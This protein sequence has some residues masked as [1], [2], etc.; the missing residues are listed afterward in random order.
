TPRRVYTHI[1]PDGDG[2]RDVFSV[3]YTLDEPARAILIVNQ[4][5][6]EVTHSK[7]LH[8][9]LAWNGK[10]DGRPVRPGN[11]TLEV[12]A[13]DPAGNVAKPFPFAIVTVRYVELGRTRILAR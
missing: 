12:S 1:S 10:L 6:V 11:Y 2:H 3:P 8:G 5:Q 7:Q 13:R 4:R 9:E